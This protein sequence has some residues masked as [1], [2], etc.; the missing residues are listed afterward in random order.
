MLKFFNANQRNFSKKLELILD[1][2]KQKQKNKSLIVKKILVDVKN[3]GD[4][5]VLKYERKFSNI[6]LKQKK[7]KFSKQEIN[8]ISKRISKN[9]KRSIDVAYSR[10]KKFHLKQKLTSFKYKD[11]YN[12]ELSY[13]YSPIDRVGVYV[14]EG[15]Q[16]ILVLF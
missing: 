7:I 3:Y 6:Q 4:K 10:I 14:P 8:K 1:A 11:K 15:L 9:L 16:A 5:A 13:K 2:R 12:N